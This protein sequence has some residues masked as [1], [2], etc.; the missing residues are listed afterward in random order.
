[1]INIS[2]QRI[3][4]LNFAIDV[5]FIL[6]LLVAL[7]VVFLIVTIKMECVKIGYEIYNLSQDIEVKKLKMQELVE[8]RD[9]M[10]QPEKLSQYS[11]SLELYPPKPDRVFYVE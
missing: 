6:E 7:I 1:M 5:F 8:L 11:N 2:I 3:K 9:S 4:P 10:V